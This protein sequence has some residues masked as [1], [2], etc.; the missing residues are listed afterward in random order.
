MNQE[1]YK[2]LHLED[3]LQIWRENSKNIEDML[4]QVSM[5][6]IS[7]GKYYAH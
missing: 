4:P 7:K 5:A 6:V 1:S 3:W 2:K